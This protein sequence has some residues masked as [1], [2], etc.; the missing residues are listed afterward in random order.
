MCSRTF[1]HSG[2]LPLSAL[3]N[4]DGSAQS[5]SYQL[6]VLLNPSNM[7]NVTEELNRH[8]NLIN[9]NVNSNTWLPYWIFLKIQLPFQLL[10]PSGLFLVIIVV[11]NFIYVCLWLLQWTF[12]FLLC[13][14][15]FYEDQSLVKKQTCAEFFQGLNSF[16]LGFKSQRLSRKGPW[17]GDWRKK[18]KS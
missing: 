10:P 17:K 6:S 11:F 4:M 2:N 15:C 14:C 9:L 1:C 8:W 7:T 16:F 5:T 18:M 3:Y 13:F 12:F